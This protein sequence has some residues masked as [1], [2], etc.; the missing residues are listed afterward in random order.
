MTGRT[1]ADPFA[2]LRWYRAAGDGLRFDRRYRLAQLPL[3][4]PGHPR[5]VE[6]SADSDYRGGRYERARVSLV[7]DLGPA[8]LQHPAYRRL[9]DALAASTFSHKVAFD[10]AE[11]RAPNVHCTLVGDIDPSPAL[12]AAA[13]RALT[14]VSPF[15]VVLHGPFVGR[16]NRGR[17]Y[18]PLEFDRPA[19]G[20]ALDALCRVYGRERPGFLAIGLVNL[21]DELDAA[22]A[23]DLA[24]LLAS[25]QQRSRLPV[26]R[27]SWTATNDDLALSM[28]RLET[29]ELR[30]A[31]DRTASARG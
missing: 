16:F 31:G 22:E 14:E 27:L 12:R 7:A 10:I 24:A 5:A 1:G 15:S 8:F 11:T 18:L 2:A 20:R 4:A 29:V 30:G 9:L 23:H 19:D 25:Q 13:R 26:T 21:R 17:I 28:R 3:V 6:T